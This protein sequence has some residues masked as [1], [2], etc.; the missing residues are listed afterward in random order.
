MPPLLPITRPPLVAVT[1]SHTWFESAVPSV[2]RC[3]SVNVRSTTSKTYSRPASSVG[4]DGRSG[5]LAGASMSPPV[6]AAKMST[7]SAPSSIRRCASNTAGGK[8]SRWP[9]AVFAAGKPWSWTLS[10]PSASRRRAAKSSDGSARMW[11]PL[12]FASASGG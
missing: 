9:R 7:R 3:P 10:G 1:S 5:A 8:S 2:K 6:R 4:S 11:Q 12:Q